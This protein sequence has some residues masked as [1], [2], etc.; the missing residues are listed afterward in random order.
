MAQLLNNPV[1]SIQRIQVGP[2]KRASINRKL[3]QRNQVMRLIW[4]LNHS[5]RKRRKGKRKKKK[6]KANKTRQ[7]R[8]SKKAKL[9]HSASQP[10]QAR[11][12][13]RRRPNRKSEPQ[14]YLLISLNI[15][16]SS[17]RQK[18]FIKKMKAK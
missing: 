15:K 9:R 16:V 17:R 8:R 1:Q 13:L 2:A 11:V 14:M 7:W 10:N 3:I 18:A 4:S 12:I 6:S 5:R